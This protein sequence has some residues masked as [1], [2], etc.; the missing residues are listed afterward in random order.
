MAADFERTSVPGVYRRGRRYVVMYRDPFGRQRKRSATTLAEARVLKS[1][2]TAS[3]ARGEYREQSRLRFDEY[4]R[5]WVAGYEGRTARGIRARTVEEYR[6]DLERDAIPHFGRMRL[7][8]IEPRHVKAFAGALADRGLAPR[9]VRN[10]LTPLR[11]LFATAVEEGLLRSN[12]CAGVRLG[13]RRRPDA[14]R[15]HGP[16]ALTEA[17]L[18]ALIDATP[19]EWR[20]LVT[21]LAHTGLRISELVALRWG[22]IDLGARRVRVRR[23]IVDGVADVPKSAYGVRDVPL[24]RALADGLAARRRR[25]SHSGD[26]DP[27]FTSPRGGLIDPRN[28]L[29]RVVKPAAVRAGVP[30]AGLHTLRHTYASLLFRSGWNAKQVQ[31]VLG[32]HSPAFTLAAYVHLMP[33]DLP[34]PVFSAQQPAGGAASTGP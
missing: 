20:L 8:E 17:Q 6:R 33:D 5:Q 25:G 24:P 22:D 31:M 7:A 4:A 27:V 30:W 9:T 15:S 32:H 21:T 11:A 26:D 28:L 13:G 1:E 10:A 23:A 16:R 19:E 14:E 34:E 29:R 12:P 3:V 2:L 18:V